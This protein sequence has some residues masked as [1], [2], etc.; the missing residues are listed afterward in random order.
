MATKNRADVSLVST[1]LAAGIYKRNQ[2]RLTRQLTVLALWVVIFLGCYV[3]SVVPL[4]DFRDPWIRVGIPTALAIAG[5]W[6]A[7]RVVNYP[8]FAD[9]LVSV[10]AEMAK[11]SWPGRD[12][13]YRATVVVIVT[14]LLLAAVLFAFDY[15]WQFFFRLIGVIHAGGGA[16]AE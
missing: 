12:E 8:K 5:A 1:L 7:Y 3:M 2:G 10:E 4:G 14:M 16:P 11:V 13:L 15:L 6:F 9:F